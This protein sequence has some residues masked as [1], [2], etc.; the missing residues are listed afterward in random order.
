MKINPHMF[1]GYDLRGVVDQDLNPEIVEHIG[2]AF[3][4]YLARHN[5][6]TAVVGYDS[7]ATGPE[8]TAQVIKGLRWAG[9]DV[10]E[11][12]MIMVGMFYW[13]QYHFK[14]KGGVMVTASHNPP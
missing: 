11:I 8:Y 4:T 14:S 6:H 13:A 3:G 5:T 7:R 10:I 12:G 9:I 1:R 2:K